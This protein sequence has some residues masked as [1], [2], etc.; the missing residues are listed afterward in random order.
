MPSCIIFEVCKLSTSAIS[1]YKLCS[2][3][4]QTNMTEFLSANIT[5]NKINGKIIGLHKANTLCTWCNNY[6][7]IGTGLSPACTRTGMT[8]TEKRVNACK[9][10]Y[11]RCRRH[12]GAT[13]H[14]PTS[15]AQL[16]GISKQSNI[17][18]LDR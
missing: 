12:M 1:M 13:K 6:R 4:Q 7:F 16:A 15:N 18:E 2:N 5:R 10:T 3:S 9:F 11:S 14:L 8:S 17:S